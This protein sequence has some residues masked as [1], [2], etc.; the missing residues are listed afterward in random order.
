M[1]L[2]LEGPKLQVMVEAPLKKLDEAIRRS[3][4]DGGSTS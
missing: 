3:A 2:T 1:T 4:L